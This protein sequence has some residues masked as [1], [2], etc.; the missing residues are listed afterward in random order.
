MSGTAA[1]LW[2]SELSPFAL[3]LRALLAYAGLPYAWLPADGS[4]WRNYRTLA[5]IERAKRARSVLR[6]PETTPL[7]EYPLVP[8]LVAGERIYYDSSAIARWLD[9]HHRPS[10][11]RFIPEDPLLGFVVRIIDEAFDEL[12]LYLVHHRR[13]VTSAASNDAG[14]RLARELRRVLPPFAGGRLARS[15][16][17]RQVRRLPYL[18]SV[19]PAGYTAPVRPALVPPSRAGFPPTHAMLD[20]IWGL[21]V[22]ALARAL[23][24]R[25]HLFGERFTLADA[26]VYGQL[27]MNLADPIAADGLRARAPGL[28]AWLRAIARDEHTAAAGPLA[29]HDDLAPLLGA[30]GR[31]FVPLMIQNEQAY[32][33][34]VA[35]GETIFNE[36]AFDRGRALY[37]GTLL[38]QPFRAVAR[39]FQVQ[40]WRELRGAF[41]ALQPAAQARITALLDVPAAS[42][43]LA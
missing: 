14:L 41:S 27:G 12:G 2:G 1:I 22:D 31:T 39:T 21:F 16:S 37:D 26:S 23:A 32:L 13:W 4:R 3:K 36:R 35:A 6:Y 34:A 8:Y 30:I 15:F 20:A 38:G 5:R 43:A 10:A 18:M 25:P 17:E 7:D 24:G 9:D 33:A 11:G 19:A 42:L 40:V 29:L 28:D